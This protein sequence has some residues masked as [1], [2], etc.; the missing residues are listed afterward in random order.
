MSGSFGD[1]GGPGR[2]FG[3]AAHHVG[4]PGGYKGDQ[5]EGDHQQN[6]GD[7]AVAV[8]QASDLNGLYSPNPRRKRRAVG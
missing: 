4:A 2:G 7:R 1:F 6:G 5:D 3:A 8:G